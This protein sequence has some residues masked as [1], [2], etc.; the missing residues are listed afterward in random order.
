[1][2]SSIGISIVVTVLARQTQTSHVEIA[3]QLSPFGDALRSD[4]FFG[5]WDW[6]TNAGAAALNGEVT[7]QA[8][9]IAYLNDFRLMMFLTVLAVPLLL[10]LRRPA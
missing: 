10:L 3:G 8:M 2:G 4:Q 6:N 1:M 5:I 7:R 9:M